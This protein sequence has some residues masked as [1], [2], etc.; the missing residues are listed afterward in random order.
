MKKIQTISIFI[1]AFCIAFSSAALPISATA[2][3]KQNRTIQTK[4]VPITL[5]SQTAAPGEKVTVKILVG[6]SQGI[7]AMDLY[8]DYD[9]KKLTYLS[10]RQ[11]S[12]FSSS[13]MTLI[14]EPNGENRVSFSY[15][16]AGTGIKKK[17][18]VLEITFRVKKKAKGRAK[19][20][21]SVGAFADSEAESVAYKVRQGAVKIKK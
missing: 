7:C 12:R 20:K 11:G 4:K 3:K 5:T 18:T 10:S 15:V 19:C 21:L 16:D 1:L 14:G 13:A 17:M 9:A 2:A 8:V 6:S